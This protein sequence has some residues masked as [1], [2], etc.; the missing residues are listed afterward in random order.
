[1]STVGIGT[2]RAPTTLYSAGTRSLL[3]GMRAHGVERLV[4]ISSE[5]ADHW[6]HQGLLKLWVV[7]PLLQ[8]LL[9]ATYDDMRR[10]DV[11]LWESAAQWT[12]IR[13]P[14]IVES[15]AKNHYRLD[16]DAALPRGWTITA[17]DLASAMLDI[18]ERADLGRR[19]VHVAKSARAG[20]EAPCPP[21]RRKS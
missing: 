12:A 7:L 3:A 20:L 19:H 13:S 5:V 10:M 11:V 18:A 17:A 1:V 8:R 2:S 9:G 4:V 14:R 15:R 16:A 6:A 21:C